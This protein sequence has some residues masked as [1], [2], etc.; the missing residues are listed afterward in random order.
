MSL[1]TTAS[2]Y[3]D[4]VKSISH[5]LIPRG[6]VAARRMGRYDVLRTAPAALEDH[7][8]VILAPVVTAPRTDC[9]RPRRRCI[10]VS[11]V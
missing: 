9:T 8:R 3:H 10:H 7:E 6:V 4:A 1:T 5:H 2:G 11:H